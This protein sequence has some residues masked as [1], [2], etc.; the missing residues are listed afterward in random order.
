MEKEQNKQGMS[1]KDW[2]AAILI[3][4][5]LAGFLFGTCIPFAMRRRRKPGNRMHWPR[6]RYR[7]RARPQARN[8]PGL[9]SR[10]PV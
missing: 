8:W 5:G 7:P 2:A 1:K 3:S 10:N 4:V 9:P 6:R